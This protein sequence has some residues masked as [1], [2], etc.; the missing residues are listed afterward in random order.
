MISFIKN[1]ENNK[2]NI[3]KNLYYIP[4]LTKLYT[5]IYMIWY[6]V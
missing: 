1:I 5:V 6:N 4:K 2:V 3:K